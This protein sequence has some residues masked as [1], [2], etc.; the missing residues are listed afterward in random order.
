M[1]LKVLI[2][3]STAVEV[4][5]LSNIFFISAK[6]LDKIQ[7]CNTLRTAIMKFCGKHQE[8]LPTNVDAKNC[9]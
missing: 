8:I 7:L 6:T 1:K 2:V 5:R 9:R 3:N 4:G